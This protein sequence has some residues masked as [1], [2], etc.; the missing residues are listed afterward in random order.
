[1]FIIFAKASCLLQRL[2]VFKENIIL[3]PPLALLLHK[4]KSIL[5]S[6]KAQQSPLDSSLS[7]MFLLRTALNLIW[8]F[9]TGRLY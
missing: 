8:S 2:W 7:L 5:E 3:L 4:L 6:V 1:M 9:V